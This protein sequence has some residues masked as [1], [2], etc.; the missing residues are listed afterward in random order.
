MKAVTGKWQSKIDFDEIEMRQKRLQLTLSFN[1]RHC[2]SKAKLDKGR[3]D[4][5]ASSAEE[6]HRGLS[7]DFCGLVGSM[8]IFSGSCTCWLQPPEMLTQIQTDLLIGS[9]GVKIQSSPVSQFAVCVSQQL[10]KQKKKKK[11]DLRDVWCTWV[12]NLTPV[13][14]RL[15]F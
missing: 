8:L 1:L 12:D 6:Q 13:P 15:Y 5:Q 3:K 2:Q 7:G 9:I 14:H 4:G 10:C 11:L